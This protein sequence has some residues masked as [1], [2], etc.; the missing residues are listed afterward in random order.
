MIHLH[1]T[2]NALVLLFHTLFHMSMPVNAM[3]VA[4]LGGGGVVQPPCKPSPR[5]SKISILNER[6]IKKKF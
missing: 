4:C 2:W 3:S 5:G 6:K 1:V